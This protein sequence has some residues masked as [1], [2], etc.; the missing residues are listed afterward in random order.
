MRKILF[1]MVAA[2]TLVACEKDDSGYMNEDDK[3]TIAAGGNIKFFQNSEPLSVVWIDK[4]AGGTITI[5]TEIDAAVSSLV[6]IVGKE[7]ISKSFYEYDIPAPEYIIKL[8]QIL[9]HKEFVTEGCKVV[10][11][12]LRKFTI[13]VEPNFSSDFFEIGFREIIETKK[14]GKVASHGSTVLQVVTK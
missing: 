3:L 7:Y 8:E 5:E 12:G 10:P 6:R 4:K 2:L 9:K 13:T 11:N 1:V 14:Y